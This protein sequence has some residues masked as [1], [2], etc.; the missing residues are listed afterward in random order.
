MFLSSHAMLAPTLVNLFVELNGFQRPI[1]PANPSDVD[2]EYELVVNT[3][4]AQ[5]QLLTQTAVMTI[6]SVAIW[7]QVWDIAVVDGR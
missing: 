1:N 5:R 2:T 4:F 7:F 3:Y 6:R